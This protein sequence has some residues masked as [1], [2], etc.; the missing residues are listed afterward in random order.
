MNVFLTELTGFTELF[1]W[2]MLSAS[3]LVG[4]KKLTPFVRNELVVEDW[5]LRWV[6]DLELHLEQS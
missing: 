2:L 3:F 4:I 1:C 5:C 6:V